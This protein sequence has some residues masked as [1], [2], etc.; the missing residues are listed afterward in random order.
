VE[1]PKNRLARKISLGT[2]KFTPSDRIVADYLLR[3]YPLGLLQSASEIAEELAINTTTVTRF[4][5]KIGYRNIKDARADFRQDIRFMANSPLDRLRT[6]NQQQAETA[7]S[8]SNVMEMDLTNIRNT[9]NSLSSETVEK[10][11]SLIE[12]NNK[13]LYTLGTRKEF[14]LA[15][16]FHIQISNFRN[17]TVL[18][19]IDNLANQL[20]DLQVGDILVTFDFRRYSLVHEKA[21]RHAAET[22]GKIIVFADSPIAP[23]ADSADCLFLVNTMASS[24][25]D[26]YTAGMTLINALMSQMVEIHGSELKEKHARL[27]SL[28]KKLDVF[29]FQ[30]EFPFNSSNGTEEGE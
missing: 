19:S 6:E 20:A 18:L 24:I 3:A 22:G 25:F 17:K 29:K 30:Q 8:I 1:H 28:Y 10:F 16:Y 13:T 9:L 4:F 5:P 26:S 15:Y 27:E 11:F 23:S 21:C 14:S 2:G 12:D 7:D